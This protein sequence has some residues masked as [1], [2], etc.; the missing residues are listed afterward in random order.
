[1][2]NNSRIMKTMIHIPSLL[3]GQKD[4]DELREDF[5]KVQFF[6]KKKSN[7]DVRSQLQNTMACFLG[8]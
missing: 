6:L 3:L 8:F 7:F 5:A 1:M 2:V 4:F